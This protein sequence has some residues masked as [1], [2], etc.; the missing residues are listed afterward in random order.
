MTRTAVKAQGQHKFEIPVDYKSSRARKNIVHEGPEA[1]QYRELSDHTAEVASL[2]RCASRHS[3]T[4]ANMEISLPAECINTLIRRQNKDTKEIDPILFSKEVDTFHRLDGSRETG[5]TY[6][7]RDFNE[8]KD[9]CNLNDSRETEGVCKPKASTE[10]V[11]VNK[12]NDTREAEDTHKLTGFTEPNDCHKL[13]DLSEMK[14]IHRLKD[15]S[16]TENALQYKFM[17]EVEQITSM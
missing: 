10:P 15:S 1:E 17:Q 4:H 9:V 2:A 8:T 6:K 12:L 3:L 7:V 14:E 11:D 13:H 16:E 5:D